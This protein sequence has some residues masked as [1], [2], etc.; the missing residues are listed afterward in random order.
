MPL[1]KGQ[2]RI[3]NQDFREYKKLEHRIKK[4]SLGIKQYH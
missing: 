2:N 1:V 4:T 3:V